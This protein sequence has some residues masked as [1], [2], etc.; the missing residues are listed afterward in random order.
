MMNVVVCVTPPPP[1]HFPDHASGY[2][3]VDDGAEDLPAR[4]PAGWGAKVYGQE[5]LGIW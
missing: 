4:H 5:L 3:P 1:G 2:N